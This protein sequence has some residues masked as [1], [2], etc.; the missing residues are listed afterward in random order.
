MCTSISSSR[1]SPFARRSMRP[2]KRPTADKK[3]TGGAGQFAEVALRISPGPRDSGI[4]FTESLSGQ[5]VDRTFRAVGRARRAQ[6]LRRRLKRRCARLSEGILAGFRAVDVKVDFYDGKMHPVDSNESPSRSPATGPSRKPLPKARPC[7][8][9]PIH[10]NRSTHSGGLR[11]QSDGRSLQPPR[12]YSRRGRGRR[13]SSH[14]RPVPAKE[15]YRY[16]S[17][18]RSLTGGRGLHSENSITTQEMPRELE[19]RMLDEAK[20]RRAG[21]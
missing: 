16:S 12:Q 3:Q 7:L 21:K 4:V 6:C 13:L 10:E 17:Q 9:E 15:L 1:A 2:P 19:Q 14:P 20:G 5:A 11:G 8:L 18:L